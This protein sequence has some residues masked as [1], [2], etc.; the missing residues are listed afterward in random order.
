MFSIGIGRPGTFHG[1]F[2]FQ[3]LQAS[4]KCW[5]IVLALFCF[6]PSGIMSMM[7]CITLALN[8]KSKCDSTLCLVTVLATPLE[9]L[10]SNCLDKRLPSHLS[11][12]G[13]TPRRKKSQTLHPGAQIP[14]PGPL[15]TG[16]VLNLLS[17]M[18]KWFL[19]IW[20][21]TENHTWIRYQ[22]QSWTLL[23]LESD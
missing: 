17:E 10:P 8:S 11:S 2:A 12:N 14:Q 6:I 16:P 4:D 5:S 1:I 23:E 13:V 15:P 22:N 9:C 19:G 21:S 7:S 18:K 3:H 20:S